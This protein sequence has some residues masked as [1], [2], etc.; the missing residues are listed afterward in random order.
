MGGSLRPDFAGQLDRDVLGFVRRGLGHSDEA[1]FNRLAL[2]HFELQYHTVGPYREY[3]DKKGVGP[4]NIARWEE[5]PAVASFAFRKLLRASLPAAEAETAYLESGVVELARKRGKIFPDGGARGVTR[6]ANALLARH[7]LLPDVE[8]IRFL[9]MVPSPKMAPGMVIASGSEDMMRRFGRPGSRF[10]ISFRGFDVRALLEALK[11]AERGGEPIALVGHTPDILGFLDACEKQGVGFD[12]PQGS[13]VCDSGGYMGRYAGCPKE[14]Y[15]G[16][17]AKVL[18]IREEFCINA[19]WICESST[20]YFDNVLKNRFSGIGGASC[21][22]DPPW[23]RTFAVDT[24]G[25]RRLPRGEVGLLRHHDLTNRGMAFAVQ[26][27]KLGYE[28][29]EGFE[30]VGRWNMQLGRAELDREVP[31]PGGRMVT[32]MKSYM[33]GRRLSKVGKIYSCLR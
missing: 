7:Y 5:I 1:E 26:T 16:K 27:D 21:K 14:H 20:V 29:G 24:A 3:C 22:E 9:L 2:R 19:L 11:G 32:R 13:R 8:K 6:Q 25:L 31:H 10:L 28:T 17:C 30:V 4:E 12:L 23:Y 18:G 33:M 15:V